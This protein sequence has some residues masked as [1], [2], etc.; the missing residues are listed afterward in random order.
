MNIAG[1]AVAFFFAVA[2]TSDNA[3]TVDYQTHVL[4]RGIYRLDIHKPATAHRAPQGHPG[5]CLAGRQDG[6]AGAWPGVGATTT[7]T[8]PASAGQ[9]GETMTDNVIPMKEHDFTTIFASD[10]GA[11]TVRLVDNG[12]DRPT[13][14]L[15]LNTDGRHEEG[16][17]VEVR[18]TDRVR[19][20]L[21]EMLK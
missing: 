20:N 11:V 4:M 3:I 7:G 19:E 12:D 10:L 15:G 14:W 5:L 21:R 6:S 18:L 8:V 17:T 16:P 2:P 13:V 1:P 9:R